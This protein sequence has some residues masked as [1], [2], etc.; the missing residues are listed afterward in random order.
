LEVLGFTPT[1][2][3]SG[4]ATKV[5]LPKSS[6]M[7]HHHMHHPHQAR[8]SIVLK[9]SGIFTPFDISIDKKKHV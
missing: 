2:G 1:L 9:C 7:N 3:Q 4:V 8:T 6:T 5:V